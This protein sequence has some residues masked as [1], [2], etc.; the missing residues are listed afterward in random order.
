MDNHHLLN[1]IM[2]PFM[3]PPLN[4][5]G[6]SLC[7]PP[8]PQSPTSSPST[9]SIRHRTDR[10]PTRH[11][12][13]QSPIPMAYESPPF[14]P[15]AQCESQSTDKSAFDWPPISIEQCIDNVHF[16]DLFQGNLSDSSSVAMPHSIR[17]LTLYLTNDTN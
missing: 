3:Q 1:T 17:Y 12:A 2:A 15:C 11:I 9:P 16:N 6:S 8:P 7:Q 4:T 10:S 13:S 14:S 5:N